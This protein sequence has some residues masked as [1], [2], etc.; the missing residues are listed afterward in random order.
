MVMSMTGYGE[1]RN[2]SFRVEMRSHN[3][4][5]CEILL[6]LAPEL[7]PL[8]HRIK[9][10]IKSK[11]SRGRIQAFIAYDLLE[12][13]NLEI[14]LG[15]AERLILRLREV[16][17]S[18]KLRDDL[19]LGH[20]ILATRDILVPKEKGYD[21]EDLWGHLKE[22]LDRAMSNLLIMRAQE[23]KGLHG[24]ILGRVKTIRH[25]LEGIKGRVDEVVVEYKER[26][27][28]RVTELTEGKRFD[29]DRLNM[30]VAIFADKSDIT[31]EVVRLTSH[32]EQVEQ[33]LGMDGPMG[34]R[35]DFLAQELNREM[36]TIASKTSNVR[37]IQ[38][39][40]EMKSE[41][42]KIR[43]QLQNIE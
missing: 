16:G 31:E 25:L 17:D 37:I 10:H 30:E 11:I 34:K 26:L 39:A 2:E 6:R 29:Q 5:F 12:K 21:L 24:D 35:L 15:A 3:H 14:D 19:S 13:G 32:L 40:V 9:E 42:E 38:D 36:N 41:L 22:A 1:G 27:L 18:L 28:K 8:E 20:L 4:R 23:G 7:T 43:E 33:T